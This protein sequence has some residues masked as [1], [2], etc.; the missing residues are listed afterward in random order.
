MLETDRRNRT[1][2][3]E[4]KPV[5]ATLQYFR[6]LW[7]VTEVDDMSE[8]LQGN[9]LLNIKKCLVQRLR[10]HS[11]VPAMN[12]FYKCSVINKGEGPELV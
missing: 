6:E 3:L 9:Q 2:T 8:C 5:S 4:V 11:F 7:T 12:N 10:R 1:T